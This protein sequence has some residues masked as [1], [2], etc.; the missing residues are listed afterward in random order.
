M[1]RPFIPSLILSFVYTF[2]CVFL[3]SEMLV[4][5][6]ALLRDGTGA[7]KTAAERPTV[8]AKHRAKQQTA[9][10]LS[11]RRMDLYRWSNLRMCAASPPDIPV[12]PSFLLSMGTATARVSNRRGQRDRPTETESESERDQQGSVTT[13]EKLLQ[14]FRLS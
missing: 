3:H 8:R 1:N 2:I 11:K 14:P 12:L 10:M 9:A 13:P 5:E 4:R 7:M 6:R